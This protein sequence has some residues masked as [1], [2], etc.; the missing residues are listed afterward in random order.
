[1]SRS[2]SVEDAIDKL[3]WFQHTTKAIYGRPV[4]TRD[5]V[6]GSDSEEI[7]TVQATAATKDK[8]KEAPHNLLTDSKL[9]RLMKAMQTLTSNYAELNSQYNKLNSQMVDMK[10][11]LAAAKDRPQVQNEPYTEKKRVFQD[12]NKPT[13]PGRRNFNR[14][15][16]NP[17]PVRCYNCDRY[18]HFSRDCPDRVPFSYRPEPVLDNR[19]KQPLNSNGSGN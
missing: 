17:P 16:E 9:D 8:K 12:R 5:P 6:P 18:G 13:P 19:N 4:R 1:M 2:S 14:Y 7:F 10:K 15:N 3:K 11:E